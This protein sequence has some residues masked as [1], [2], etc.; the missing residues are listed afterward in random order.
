VIHNKVVGIIS[1]MKEEWAAVVREDQNCHTE[2]M[3]GNY[4]YYVTLQIYE[5]KYV[6]K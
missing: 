3:S 1:S 2:S 6:Q 4:Y 5:N